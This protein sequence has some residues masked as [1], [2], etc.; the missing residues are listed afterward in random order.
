MALPG[1]NDESNGYNTLIKNGESNNANDVKAVIPPLGAV[2]PWL[3]TLTGTPSLPD[4]WVECDGS[5]ISDTDSP[6]DGVTIPDLNGNNYFLR[7]NSTSGGTG[8]ASS[9]TS[10]TPSAA[11]FADD[12]VPAGG[13]TF[14]KSKYG[15]H[16]HSVST[17]PP[18]YDMVWI[19]RIK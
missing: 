6:Y 4:G 9:V 19:M 11:S 1:N 12:Y 3:K 10:S 8:G 2:M 18:Y 5:T 7:G 15:D 13:A 16:T 17:L 14:N